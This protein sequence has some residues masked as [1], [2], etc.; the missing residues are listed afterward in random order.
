[1]QASNERV[2]DIVQENV[3][4]VPNAWSPKQR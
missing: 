1:M 2:L 3:L 4:S